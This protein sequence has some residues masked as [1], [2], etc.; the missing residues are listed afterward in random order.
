MVGCRNMGGWRTLLTA[1]GCIVVSILFCLCSPADKGERGEPMNAAYYWSTVF[2]LDSAQQ[3]FI[4]DQHI[5]RI[6]LRYFD[7]VMKDGKPMPNATVQFAS[8]LPKG[9]ET[10]PTIYIVNS[11]METDHRDLDSL[12]LSRILQMS[13]THDMGPIREIQ[14]DCDWTKQTCGNYFALLERLKERAKAHDIRLSATIRLHQL[15]QPTPPVDRGVLM[16]YNTGDVTKFDG[17]DPILD[18]H[19]VKPY[20][21]YLKDYD[22]PLSTAYPVFAW[23][24]VFRR[25]DGLR[26]KVKGLR[27]NREALLPSEATKRK[28]KGQRSKDKGAWRYI[29]IL[30]RDDYL[31]ILPDDSIVVRQPTPDM[32]RQ[33]R[34]AVDSLRP[35][36]NREVILYD[37]SRQNIQR[38]KQYHYEKVI[39]L[40]PAGS[41]TRAE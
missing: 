19:D 3:A 13:E 22:L 24:V 15:S 18:M 2:S 20:L 11:C 1:I 31:P 30:H 29:G 21:R 33:A 8:A 37:I 16:M 7:V 10:V 26:S 9:V 25:G 5:G 17:T 36:A 32:V 6:Y 4:R 12:L 34:Q 41:G 27:S 14:L 35:D 38:I 23:Q 40:S 39:F 28:V